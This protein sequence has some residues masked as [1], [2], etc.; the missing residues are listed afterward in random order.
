MLRRIL[1]LLLL[2]IGDT[3]FATPTIR[4]LRR[5]HPRARI[6]ALVYPSNAGILA[7]NPDI[8]RLILHPTAATWNGW[9]EYLGLLWRLN[10]MRFDLLV[11]FAP[12]QWWMT[13]ALRPHRYRP[14]AFPVWQWF[15]PFGQRPWR[16]RHAVSSYATLLTARERANLPSAPVLSATP[17]DR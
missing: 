2:P 3:L 10:R 14:L 8:D 13:Q 15:L 6:V 16:Y 7:A 11:Q 12:G 9:G 17:E 5:S 4:A 1:L